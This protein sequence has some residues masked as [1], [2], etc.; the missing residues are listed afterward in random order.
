MEVKFLCEI[1]EQSSPNVENIR[2]GALL[3]GTSDTCVA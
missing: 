3:V 1:S 2:V